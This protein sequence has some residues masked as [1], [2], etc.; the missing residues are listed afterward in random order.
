MEMYTIIVLNGG[1]YEIDKQYIQ[2]T[3]GQDAILKY[4]KEY[5]PQLEKDDTI[6]IK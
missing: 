3:S 6:K 4:I 2:A 1:G 5:R